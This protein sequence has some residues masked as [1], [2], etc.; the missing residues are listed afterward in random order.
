MCA[1]YS[2]IRGCLDEE[3][4]SFKDWINSAVNHL[5]IISKDKYMEVLGWQLQRCEDGTNQLLRTTTSS[6]RNFIQPMNGLGLFKTCLSAGL[7]VN[8]VQSIVDKLS[9]PSYDVICMTT[10]PTQ[11]SPR[12]RT[13]TTSHQA[14]RRKK[15]DPSPPVTPFFPETQYLPIFDKTDGNEMSETHGTFYHEYPQHYE[16][17]DTETFLTMDCSSIDMMLG[18]LLNNESVGQT[19][20]SG[21]NDGSL[22]DMDLQLDC[23]TLGTEYSHPIRTTPS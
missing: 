5:G 15:G 19:D 11:I 12:S 2:A 13:A 8:N 6:V 10:Q 7:Q 18:T 3:K 1:V 20:I 14:S 21:S 9:G 22:F 16:G 23:S 4:I 17:L